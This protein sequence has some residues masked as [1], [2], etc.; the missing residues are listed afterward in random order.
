[1]N[2][3][4]RRLGLDDGGSWRRRERGLNLR[5]GKKEK[6]WEFREREEGGGG[7]NEEKVKEA[8]TVV[9]TAMAFLSEEKKI[10]L[11]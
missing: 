6:G 7:G 9:D 11:K 4:R 10:E 3:L 2:V 5:G 8:V 1:M